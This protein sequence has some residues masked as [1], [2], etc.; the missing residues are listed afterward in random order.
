MTTLPPDENVIRGPWPL[1]TDHLHE[2]YSVRPTHEPATGLVVVPLA[3]GMEP[4]RFR[5]HDAL[6]L[7]GQ[8]VAQAHLVQGKPIPA[9]VSLTWDGYVPPAPWVAAQPASNPPQQDPAN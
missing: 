7:A 8:L 2:T 4:L 9:Q 3:Q 6:Q 5:P 1:R